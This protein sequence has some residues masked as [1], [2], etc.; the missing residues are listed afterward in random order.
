MSLPPSIRFLTLDAVLRLHDGIIRDQRGDPGIRDRGLLEAA[1]AMPAQR[2][3]G[4][5]LHPDIPAMAGAYAFHICRN[6]PFVDG[7]KRVALAAMIAFLTENGWSLDADRDDAFSTVM[8]LAAGELGKD[9]LTEW[10]RRNSH[11]K[12]GLELREL[13]GAMIPDAVRE[14]QAAIDRSPPIEVAASVHEASGA[15]PLLAERLRVSESA[16]D[17]RLR[18][19]AL[20]QAVLLL[21]IYR[22]AEDL[23]YEW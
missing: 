3:G 8:S 9:A 19:A 4:E 7:N 21:C 11:R 14:T 23:G 18:T 20:G 15:M 2:F 17:E 5:Y 10:V 6:H 12:A 22:V 16:P 13:F 1:I